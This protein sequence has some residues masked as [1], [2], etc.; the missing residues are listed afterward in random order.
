MVHFSLCELGV[1]RHHPYGPFC[2][3]NHG[4]NPIFD[5]MVA[6][7]PDLW[8]SL[9][10]IVFTSRPAWQ[11][12]PF[13]RVGLTISTVEFLKNYFIIMMDVTLLLSQPSLAVRCLHALS[14]TQSTNKKQYGVVI[15]A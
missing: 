13:F 12:A 5:E 9:V 14:S 15:V 1:T 10:H 7:C 2:N 3:F 8:L 11:R 6:F 4:R